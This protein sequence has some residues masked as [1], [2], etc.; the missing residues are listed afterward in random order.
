MRGPVWI[1]NPLYRWF[2]GLSPDDPVWDPTTFTKNR[3][4]PQ[5]GEVFEKFMTMLLT[6]PEA[7]PLLPDDVGLRDEAVFD[8]G[9]IAQIDR[10]IP[11]HLDGQ[12]VQ[13]Q[14]RPRRAV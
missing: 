10:G 2:V 12:I 3:E 7:K 5:Q 11:H 14:Y 1:Y 4:R 6:H 13:L 9:D 8:R